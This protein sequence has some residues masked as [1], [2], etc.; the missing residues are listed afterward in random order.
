MSL[1]SG[2]LSGYSEQ[3]SVINNNPQVLSTLLQLSKQFE[4][5][6]KK[7]QSSCVYLLC[8]QARRY[9]YLHWRPSSI[10]GICRHL[11]MT[12]LKA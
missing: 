8:D 11:D 1:R 12:N 9:I 4:V 6:N 5:F 3:E 2:E 7:L 10:A